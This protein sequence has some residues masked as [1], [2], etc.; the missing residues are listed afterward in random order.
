MTDATRPADCNCA[1][2]PFHHARK[3]PV[4][5]R[6]TLYLMD[7]RIGVLSSSSLVEQCVADE[8]LAIVTECQL[9]GKP[10]TRAR[11]DFFRSAT[12][13]GN[14]ALVKLD[15][16]LRQLGK[17][18]ERTGVVRPAPQLPVRDYSREVEELFKRTIK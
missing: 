1:D 3:C 16:A 12:G 4:Q 11:L 5:V 13:Y 15:Q 9:S 2:W 6:R 14:S 18:R 7:R 10:P 17:P 8:V